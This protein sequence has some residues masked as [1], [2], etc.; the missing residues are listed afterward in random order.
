MLR[1][2]LLLAL[3]S[4]ICVVSPTFTAARSLQAGAPRS[5]APNTREDD[6][7]LR[8]FTLS[9]VDFLAQSAVTGNWS[10]AAY[11]SLQLDGCSFIPQPYKAQQP[12]GRP[13]WTKAER[14]RLQTHNALEAAP[15]AD[16][17]W[18]V[19]VAPDGSDANTG[20]VAA[21]LQSIHRALALSRQ[22]A[23]PT[24]YKYNAASP[25]ACITLRAG[26]YYLGY[27]ASAANT[28]TDSRVGA[29]HLTPADSGLT[30]R[31]MEGETV[32][33]SGGVPLNV[34]WQQWRNGSY[35]TSLADST[36][37]AFDRWHFN[38]LYVDNQRAVRAKFPNG[39]PAIHGLWDN[40][41][42]APQAKT[43]SPPTNYPSATDISVSSP[44]RPGHFKTYQMGVGG[45]AAVFDPP[46]SFW[47]SDSPPA[48]A[49]F[50][51]PSG[52]TVDDST[53]NRSVG[54]SDLT[55]G[56]AYVFAF[57][58][59]HWGSWA[60]E[61]ASYSAITGEVTFGA[62]GFQEARGSGS[63]AE[64][65]ISNVLEELDAPNEFYVSYSN[66][67][68]Y[69][70]PNTST[71][72]SSPSPTYIASQL[73]CILSI[74]GNPTTPVNDV[75]IVG[76]TFAHTAST[77]LRPY[78]VPSGGDW[79]VHRGGAVFLD[80]TANVFIGRSTF[81]QLGGNGVVLSNFNM[82]PTIVFSEFVWLGE[83]GIV[84]LGSVSGIDGVTNTQQPTA[85]FLVANLLHELGAYI[86]QTAGIVQFLSRRT[87]VGKSAIFN[88]PRA[89]I[90]IN[91]GFGGG[92]SIE[93]N[94]IFNTVRETS[95]HGPIN[96]WDREPY[97][98][99]NGGGP[100]VIPERNY[101]TAN[102]L[103][104]AY[105]SVWPIDQSEAALLCIHL[106]VA[107]MLLVPACR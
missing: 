73:P 37:P 103:F 50:V 75:S 76:I 34:A 56:P 96:S 53:R 79:S 15:H 39:D 45:P 100:S 24:P 72:H 5:A 102:L 65:Y 92:L 32:T 90:N 91:D 29:I 30:I 48:G 69:Y 9:Y 54:W 61:V 17:Q 28:A 104:N 62:G 13:E 12:V 25:I 67:T 58:N 80:N 21:P 47:A 26:T 6:C 94:V 57:H 55:D 14:E 11:D 101:I 71:P 74:Q 97:L 95:D 1:S 77:F 107:T 70:Q 60:F 87:Y 16:C 59:G 64:W 46:Q 78:E 49:K 66:N 43:W 89:G 51:V 88:V 20:D 19:F 36:I 68:L 7:R 27:N 83:S 10:Q 105:S 98:V 8:H 35:V 41:G 99:D 40:T 22:V 84:L 18:E 85:T 42:W 33:L 23:R 44:Q 4:L 106:A 2:N 81:T 38:E 3:L 93:G 86:K 31:G 82:A 52:L 63:G